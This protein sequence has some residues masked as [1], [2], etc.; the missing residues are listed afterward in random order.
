MQTWVVDVRRVRSLRKYRFVRVSDGQTLVQGETD[1]V[2]VNVETGFPQ[3][4]PPE[5]IKVLGLE[6]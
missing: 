2:L 4:I 1:W 3:R 6:P 5:I